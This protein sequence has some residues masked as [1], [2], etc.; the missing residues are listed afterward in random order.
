MKSEHITHESY[1]QIRVVK[2]TGNGCEFFGSDIVHSGGITL[3]I[4]RCSVDEKYNS[5]FFHEEEELIRVQMSN[6]QYVDMITSAMNTQGV[7][8]TLIRTEN[9]RVPQI[10]HVE[11]KVEKFKRSMQDT[12]AT[13][14]KQI[15]SIIE[16]LST[17]TL[18]KRKVAELTGDLKLLQSHIKSN[19]PF[20]MDC[21][22][23]QMESTITEAKQSVSLY[24]DSK[25]QALG[26]EHLKNDMMV[27][28][29]APK[30]DENE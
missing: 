14:R 26:I 17:G 15:D 29:E 10:S 5:K 7:P 1:G 23:E 11:D 3:E 16:K 4:S 22:E 21:F 2:F 13:Y 27:Q 25:V 6:S 19:T 28:I 30:K 24:V 20:V 9:R 8:C 12:Q 18:G